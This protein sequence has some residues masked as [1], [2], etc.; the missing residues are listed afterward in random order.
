MA[1]FSRLACFTQQT[2]KKEKLLWSTAN[3]WCHLNGDWSDC[4]IS[5]KDSKLET[6]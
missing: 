4:R 1:S 6:T 5:S 3:N 2:K